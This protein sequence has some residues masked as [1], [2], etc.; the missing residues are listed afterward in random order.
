MSRNAKR[1][2]RA[3]QHAREWQQTFDAI[4]DIVALISPDF[5]FV[6]VNRAG[7]MAAGKTEAELVGRRCYEAVH[8][9]NEPIAGCPC[10]KMMKTGKP[11][12]GEFSVAG[13]HFIATADPVLD[14]KGKLVAFTHTVKDITDRKRAEDDLA[15]H[16]EHL[17]ELVEERTR[18]LNRAQDELLRQSRLATLGRVAGGLAQELSVPLAAAREAAE[19][20]SR[21]LTPDAGIEAARQLASVQREADRAE[22]MAAAIIGFVQQSRSRARRCSLRRILNAAVVHAALPGNVSVHLELPSRLPL[23]RVDEPRMVVVFDHLLANAAQAMPDG[24][25]IGV[26]ATVEKGMVSVAVRDTGSGIAPEHMERL[27]E[28]L[29][30][31]RPLGAGIGLSMCKA[32]V[33][34]DRGAIAVK[35]EPGSG[36][37]VTVRLPGVRGTQS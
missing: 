37:T 20:L 13:R 8:G 32:F 21:A 24:G 25:T 11:S 6:R 15:L 12:S 34:A 1:A 10:A 7:C 3:G 19:R 29:F 5:R 16:R 14:G 9:T 28:P 27:F 2:A 30:S 4:T 23:V 33:E 35:S 31:T 18:E 36:T 26:F 17:A 22:R